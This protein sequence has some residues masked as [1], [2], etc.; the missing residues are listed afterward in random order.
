MADNG[1]LLSAMAKL[2]RVKPEGSVLMGGRPIDMERPVINN[3]DGSFST[4]RTATYEM[5]GKHYVI[6]TIVA[7]I[8]HDPDSALGLWRQGKNREVGVFGSADEANQYAK[9]RTL[10]IGQK[11]GR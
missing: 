8:Q 2:L 11:R 3:P 5:D 4:E 1:M 9:Q 7:G 6:P 10:S